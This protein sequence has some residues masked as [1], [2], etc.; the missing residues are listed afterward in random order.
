[1]PTFTIIGSGQTPSGLNEI[2]A[3]GTI[4]VN[5]G[6]IFIV[7]PSADDDVNFSSA[8][9]S[10]TNFVV[11]FG[12]TNA[13]NLDLTFGNSL[14]P[15]IEIADNVNLDSI[16]LDAGSAES[17][18]LTAG[19]GVTLDR[20]DGS[21]GADTITAGDNFV[22][23][24]N[25]NTGGGDDVISIG[26]G[27]TLADLN[28][29]TGDDTVSI[30]DGSTVGDIETRAGDDEIT[31]GDNVTVND[32]ATAGG[33]DT[34]TIGDGADV[35]NIN[36]GADP[37]SLTVGD[38]FTGNRIQM[39]SGDD[40]A[41][42]GANANANR[43]NG[44]A[45]SDTLRTET[46]PT[47]I[48]E[49]R[50]EDIQVVCFCTG[51]RITTK[52]GLVAIEDLSIGDMV[53]TMDNGYCPIRWLGRNTLD[54]IDLQMNPKLR[55]VRIAAGALGPNMPE[56]ALMVSPQ[57][58]VLIRSVI[59]LRMFGTKEVLIPAIK[60]C[61]MDGIE[62]M[63]D[64]TEVGYWH[65]LFDGHEIVYSNGAATESLFTG[66][67]ALKCVSA[68]SRREIVA[69]FPEIAVPGYVA[70]PARLIPEMGKFMKQLA[71][72][73]AKNERILFAEAP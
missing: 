6:D 60:L 19:N 48:N 24:A 58:R 13:N 33:A 57:H 44:G 11:Q 56:K 16:R 62:Q 31:L 32:I 1:M 35:N 70:T 51:T 10:S 54:S 15:S 30:G 28:T 45:G 59:A 69:L 47:V 25:L 22:L 3:G 2:P 55:P 68:E 17:S 7:D 27:A 73:H 4:Q 66:P 71:A 18:S 37:D 38:D 67:E 42:V 8:S 39:G 12:Q 34:I 41:R 26:S 9:G 36:M 64:A 5:D 49:R 29:G 65:M 20:F 72:R 46:D 63:T 40:F 21:N 52:R 43:F 61:G 23:N 50:F 53:L 14:N